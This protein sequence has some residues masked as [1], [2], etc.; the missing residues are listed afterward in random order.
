M[1]VGMSQTVSV[2]EI[3]Q[4]TAAVL[5][6]VRAGEEIVITYHGRPQARLVPYEPRSTYE[7]LVAEGVVIP[8]EREGVVI[9]QTYALGRRLDDLLAEERADRLWR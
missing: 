7:R 4:N 3:N 9:E 8:S 5:E 6:R 1:L 2:R